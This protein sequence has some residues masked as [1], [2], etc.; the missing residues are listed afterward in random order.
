MKLF[1]FALL[2]SIFV[3]SCGPS[4]EEQEKQRIQDSIKAEEDRLRAI[5]DLDS[6][7]FGDEVEESNDTL[8]AE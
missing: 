8:A 1:V 6:F 2:I 7:V 3:V 4:A 5:D